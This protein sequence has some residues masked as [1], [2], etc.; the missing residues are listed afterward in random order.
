MP[1]LTIAQALK[2]EHPLVTP[3]AHDALT[4]RLIQGAGF[5]A[6]AIG[7]SSLLATRLGLPDIG[8][9]GVTD[10]TDGIRDIASATDLPFLPM[11]LTVFS[12]LVFAQWKTTN[13]LA[14]SCAARCIHH[15]QNAP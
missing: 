7:G 4:A 13:G 8:L 10:M 15:Q 14:K 9:V 5:R 3:I 2:L 6:F 1:E 12:L 11:L